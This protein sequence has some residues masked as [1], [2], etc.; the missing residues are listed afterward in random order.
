M[1]QSMSRLVTRFVAG[2]GVLFALSYSAAIPQSDAQWRVQP[3]NASKET[4]AARVQRKAREFEAKMPLW[5]AGGGDPNQIRALAEPLDLHLKAGRADRAE[6]ILDELLKL[7]S[8]APS[9]PGA[10]GDPVSTAPKVV[11]L[12]RIPDSA[13]IVFHDDQLIYVM[14]AAGENITQIT[15]DR[16]RHFEHVAVSHD[17]RRIVANY[18]ADP[19]RGRQS[20]KLVLF[21]LEAGTEQ[22]LVPQFRM[23]GNGGVDWDPDGNIYFAGVERWPF[24]RSLSREQLLANAGANDVYRVRYDGSDLRRLTHTGDRGEADVSVAAD[25]TRIAYVATHIDPPYDSTEIWVNS[26]DGGSP[27]LVYEGGKMGVESVHDPELS[28]DGTEVIFSKVNADYKNFRFVPA[29]NTAHDLYRV[30]LDGS[31]LWRITEP[32]PISVIPDWVND[33][34]LFLLLSDRE[35]TSFRGIA[36][37]YSDGSG[38]RQINSRANIAKWIPEAR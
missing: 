12:S 2:A 25:G 5:V 19:A 32:G 29:A 30:R 35:A 28:P 3:A 13:E 1:G 9:A 20:S 21:D 6:P 31:G 8:G 16:G 22:A 14:D 38:A 7:V 33:K 15:F 26:S 24:E 18:F 10:S 23:A 11:P 4:V 17:R 36:V 37:M 34:V 27:Q